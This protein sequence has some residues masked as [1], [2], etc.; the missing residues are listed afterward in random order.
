M[1]LNLESHRPFFSVIMPVFNGQAYVEET[2]ESVLAQ[3]D[4]DW[5]FVIVDD[6]SN[7]H[8]PAI[9]EHYATKDKRIR[10]F[11]N[12]KSCKVA[13]SLNRAIEEARGRLMVRLDAD[14][15]FRPHYLTTLRPHAEHET[16]P[17]TFFSAWTTV[18]DECGETILDVRLPN[19]DKIK[20]MMRIEN[21]L[22]H[23]ATSFTKELW[24]KA[25]GYPEDPDIAE[26]TAMWN[27]FF[28]ANAKLVMIPQFLVKYRLHYTNL[29]S[30]KD[31]HLRRDQAE[32]HD[33]RTI[34]QNK[35]W[36][37]SLFLKQKMLKPAREEI[38]KLVKIQ[39]HWSF[40]N[41][42][43]YFLTFLPEFFVQFYMWELRPRARAFIK[44]LRSK[45]AWA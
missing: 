4:Q 24:R 43:Y 34:R 28:D 42:Q 11:R 39:K 9:L 8:T 15:L 12:N 25:G 10:L 13:K 38:I 44:K 5:E 37:I 22:Y 6:Y 33:L 31:A 21:F 41:R 35:E 14:D 26:D 32:A 16:S 45:K 30:I 3:T 2:I 17:Y 36:R 19:A 40:K 23:P 20:Q 1:S 27:K 29:T 18:V 7:D